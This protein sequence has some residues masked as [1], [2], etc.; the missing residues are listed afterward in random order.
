MKR[1]KEKVYEKTRTS[2]CSEGSKVSDAQSARKRTVY[3]CM[4]DMCK[5][6]RFF[7]IFFS[8]NEIVSRMCLYR[9]WEIYYNRP[10][11]II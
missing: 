5:I 2:L 3:M 6:W 4:R 8:V 10:R 7:F 1:E 9:N 11:Y